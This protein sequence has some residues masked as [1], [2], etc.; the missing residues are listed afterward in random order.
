MYRVKDVRKLPFKGLEGRG[1]KADLY[2][3]ETLVASFLDE[4]NGGSY[5]F[6]WVDELPMKVFHAHLKTLPPT[7]FMG[8]TLDWSADM[9]VAD[10]A[11][12]AEALQVTAKAMK[13]DL[14]IQL[15]DGSLRAFSIKK[16]GAER[17]RELA[18]VKYPTATIVNDLPIEQAAKILVK[19][20]D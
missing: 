16:V 12:K 3:G 10:L 6:T 8:Q 15:A 20:E 17:A 1:Y 5:I 13:K 9:F 19:M 7:E 11:E 18:K 2:H 4:G 14:V